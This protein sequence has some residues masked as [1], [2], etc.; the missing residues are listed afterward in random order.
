LSE[1]VCSRK[2]SPFVPLCLDQ[3]TR[4]SLEGEKR[5]L[6]FE[7]LERAVQQDQSPSPEHCARPRL[8]TDIGTARFAD[9][10]EEQAQGVVKYLYLDH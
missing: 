10:C 7:N 4:H 2:Q 5:E 6:T 9:G 1:G 8:A 3:K